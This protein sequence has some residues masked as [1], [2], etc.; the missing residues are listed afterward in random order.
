MQVE[1]L[2]ER[3]CKR[4]YCRRA[5]KRSA[6]GEVVGRISLLTVESP[7]TSEEKGRVETMSAQPIVSAN[8]NKKKR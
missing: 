2:I 1:I 8:V 4:V 7:F 3:D 5:C 6:P